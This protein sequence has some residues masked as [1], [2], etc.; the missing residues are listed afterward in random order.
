MAKKTSEKDFVQVRLELP[1][2]RFDVVLYFN[3]FGIES[4]DG[5]KLV[6]FALETPGKL[7]VSW[8][9]FFESDMLAKQKEDW[10]RYATEVGLPET[11]AREAWKP[12][13]MA[14]APISNFV[15]WSRRGDQAEIRC[16]NYSFG[17]IVVGSREKPKEQLTV[18]TQG[19]ALL[20]CSLE[21]QR[22]LLLALYEDLF[23]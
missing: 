6:H 3:R 15:A 14:A 12:T 9:C 13:M 23:L 21:S 17:E 20:R 10:L 1:Q 16:F 4:L 22:Q 11:E 5:H 7:A 19:L 18:T 8:S 2:G